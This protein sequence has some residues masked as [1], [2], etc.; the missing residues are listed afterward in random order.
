MKES[1]YA[2]EGA[3]AASRRYLHKTGANWTLNY[4]N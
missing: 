4:E 2:I 3:F 1:S